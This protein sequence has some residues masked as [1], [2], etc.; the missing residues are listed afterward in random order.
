MADS[1]TVDPAAELD[2]LSAF[3]DDTGAYLNTL[4]EDEL[5]EPVPSVSDWSP[6]QHL[7]HIWRANAS[8]LKAANV[9]AEGRMETQPPELSESGKQVLREQSIPRG[10]G[11]A[12]DR[13]RPPD[14]LDRQE[15]RETWTRSRDK[16]DEVASKADAL[17]DAAGGL[18]HPYWGTLTAAEWLRA[19]HVH[20][21]HHAAIVSDILAKR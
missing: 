20:S 21:D 1:L 11:Q 10:V 5:F 18:P 13:L 7:Y 9:L 2:A 15:L 4:A 17:A 16:L 14:D 19:A 12:P 6:A 8:M 3:Y